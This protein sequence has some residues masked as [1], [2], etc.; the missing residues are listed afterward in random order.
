MLQICFR[1]RK[2][3]ILKS[4]LWTLLLTWL[5]RGFLLW[6]HVSF[7]QRN[8]LGWYLEKKCWLFSSFIFL[9]F[10]SLCL[11]V[12]FSYFPFSALFLLV[13][14]V[15][16]PTITLP[17]QRKSEK[18]Q[19]FSH[20]LKVKNE[21]DWNGSKHRSECALCLG[22]GRQESEGQLLKAKKRSRIRIGESWELR[23]PRGEKFSFLESESQDLWL[24]AR[25][26]K[27]PPREERAGGCLGW[28]PTL[29]AKVR[30]TLFL[31]LLSAFFP[32]LGKV[33]GEC[34]PLPRPS[35]R[36]S[37]LPFS[38]R[39]VTTP[40]RPGA[41]TSTS[42]CATRTAPVL[43]T[44]STCSPPCLRCAAHKG[45]AAASWS[46][47]GFTLHFVLSFLCFI[48]SSVHCGD[49]V[50][51]GSGCR[52]VILAGPSGFHWRHQ[53]QAGSQAFGTTGGVFS[54][55]HPP[56]PFHF[57]LWC[58]SFFFVVFPYLLSPLT[59]N[60]FNLPACDTFWEVDSLE[61]IMR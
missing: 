19:N 28:E 43:C 57:D 31:T 27:Q 8:S 26:Q 36:P 32:A 1:R 50:L 61:D 55:A 12:N 7:C 25:L 11:T 24:R 4:L 29:P 13:I 18:I 30:R 10:V 2:V 51:G 60:S 47:P 38:P 35:S 44:R 59:M 42:S 37:L 21:K 54:Q 46:L 9:S 17:P 34:R 45:S 49:V 40:R 48:L 58:T 39:P 15:Y 33:R 6:W 53:A 5:D 56:A 22:K 23:N 41:A 52:N 20:F 14:Y 3:R 16:A